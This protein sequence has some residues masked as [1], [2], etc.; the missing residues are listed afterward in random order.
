MT[1]FS[2]SLSA[3]GGKEQAFVSDWEDIFRGWLSG[4]LSEDRSL[5]SFWADTLSPKIVYWPLAAIFLGQTH[6]Q[7]QFPP[8]KLELIYTDLA[9]KTIQL[10]RERWEEESGLL[11]LYGPKESL[12]SESDFWP[13]G[14]HT[15]IAGPCFL[16]LTIHALEN[17]IALGGQLNK[18]IQEL[19]Q[20]YELLIY[21]VNEHLW[22]EAY[23]TYFPFDLNKKEQIISD[24]IGGLL[25]WIVDVPDQ[26]Q[27][28]AMYR[29]L[30]NNFVHPQHYYFPTA[31]VNTDGQS[32]KVD[33]LINYLL[34]YGLCRFDF[35]ATA[36]ALRQHTQYLVEEYGSRALYDSNRHPKQRVPEKTNEVFPTQLWQV[37]RQASLQ[38]YSNQE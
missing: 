30:A 4:H 31:C 18:D 22:N 35:G 29:T 36:K 20:Y 24:S 2:E 37:L 16:A 12:L 34:F 28:E 26:E 11:Y 33:L 19:S 13:K 17:L 1:S 23:G 14:S 27:A 7:H 10:I 38:H 6:R 15:R 5:P 25:F 8:A 21:G 9:V 32:R 3:S